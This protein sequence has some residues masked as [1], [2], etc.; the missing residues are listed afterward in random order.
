ML[1]DCGKE[2]K[3]GAVLTEGGNMIDYAECEDCGIVEVMG[4]DVEDME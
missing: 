1:C 3:S 4:M 2:L